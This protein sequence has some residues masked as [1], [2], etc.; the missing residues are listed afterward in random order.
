MKRLLSLSLLLSVSLTGALAAKPQDPGNTQFAC[1]LY[2]KL[3]Q[4]KGN[5]FLSPFSVSSALSMVLEGARGDTLK[6]MQGVLHAEA[7]DAQRY[8]ELNKPNEAYQLSVANRVWPNKKIKLSPKFSQAIKA[9][10]GATI[11]SVDF[12]AS[13]A[14]SIINKW[15][16][17]Q[18]NGKIRDLL[19]P[20]SLDATTQVVVTNAIYFKGRWQS[21][22]QQELTKDDKFESADSSKVACKLMQQQGHFDYAK[23]DGVQIV[24]LPYLGGRLSMLV[25]LPSSQAEL[26]KLEKSFDPQHWNKWTSTLRSSLVSLSLPR[27]KQNWEAELSTVLKSLGIKK[28]FLAKESDLSGISSDI[29]KLFISGIF[30]KSFVD[31]NEFGTEAAAATAIAMAGGAAPRP[32]K[33]IEFKANHTFIYA[34]RDRQTGTILF[35]GRLDRP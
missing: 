18:T 33:P 20:N 2:T 22:F 13:D 5:I 30:H 4:A 29:K 12:V 6:E 3:S 24:E 1:Q 25:L 31:V 16:E 27:F 7:D 9:G 21:P 34:I 17:K 32:E 28:V 19:P 35:L 11:D 10:F 23:V 26:A 14:R 15:V 8:R